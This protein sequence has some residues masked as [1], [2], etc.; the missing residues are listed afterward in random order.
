[1]A[2]LDGTLPGVDSVELAR[3]LRPSRCPGSHEPMPPT[4]PSALC[5]CGGVFE[6]PAETPARRPW[7]LPE[8]E[9]RRA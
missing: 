8:H 9:G 4:C 7:F 1:M 3:V 6:K 2:I 5:L